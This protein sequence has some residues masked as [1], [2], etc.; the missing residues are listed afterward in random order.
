MESYCLNCVNVHLGEKVVQARLIHVS[1]VAPQ[2]SLFGPHSGLFQTTSRYQDRS[3]EVAQQAL[4]FVLFQL[5]VRH[6]PRFFDVSFSEVLPPE[7]AH[8]PIIFVCSRL[9]AFKNCVDVLNLFVVS[10]IFAVDTVPLIS[11]S[12]GSFT[13]LIIIIIIG[14]FYT[15]FRPT[16]ENCLF[17]SQ[18][19]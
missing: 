19:E 6:F 4:S 3:A 11:V 1:L 9:F 14:Y 7:T 8:D 18:V 15:F 16:Q 10:K 2:L 12:V 13:V 17:F 5:E